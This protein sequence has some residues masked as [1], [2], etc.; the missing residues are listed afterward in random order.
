MKIVYLEAT[1][2]ELS[3]NKRVGDAICDA[4]QRM[5]DAI[6]RVDISNAKIAE[7][8]NAENNYDDNEG[9]EYDADED[10]S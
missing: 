8:L 1:S 10:N 4:V 7:I 3:A 6:A 2:E 9:D 5:L